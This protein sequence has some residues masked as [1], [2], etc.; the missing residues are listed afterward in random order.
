[1]M[2]YYIW[3]FLLAIKCFFSLTFMS[4]FDII[5]MVKDMQ[6]R[7]EWLL[8][9]NLDVVKS[10]VILIIGLGG[11]GSYAL[12]TLARTYFKKII[13]VDGDKIDISN[14]NRQL[15]S[16]VNNIGCYKTDVWQE[17]ILKINPS[18]EVIKI[19]EFINKENL[20][21]LFQSE[22][23]YVIDACDTVET[24]KEIIKYCLKNKIKFISVMGMANRID[25]SYVKFSYL[26]KTCYD[27]LAKKLRLLLKKDN[28]KGKIPVIYSEEI[29]IKNR[30]LGSIAHVPAIAGILCTNYIINDILKGVIHE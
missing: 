7:L 5:M 10:K 27:P 30:N 20:Y 25:A 15:M 16:N 29:P 24:K 8:K 13:I 11:V 9:D 28:I 22:V 26:D 2:I 19:T 23:D 1:M 3:L 14:L 4:F 6:E 12:E 18:C 17:R 21:K